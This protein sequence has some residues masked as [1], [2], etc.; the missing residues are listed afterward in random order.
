VTSTVWRVRYPLIQ[1]RGVDQINPSIDRST[2][3]VISVNSINA[4]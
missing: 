3:N 4:H 2:R 1:R